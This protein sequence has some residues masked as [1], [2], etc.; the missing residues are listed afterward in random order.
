VRDIAPGEEITDDYGTLNLEEPFPCLCDAPNCRGRVMPDD[1]VRHAGEWDKLI[2]AAFPSIGRVDQPLWDL[3][4]EK[5]E[6]ER[7]LRGELELPSI[8]KH[9]RSA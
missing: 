9:Y 6:V 8:L 3:V 1:P 2:A 5:A 4:A 7:V